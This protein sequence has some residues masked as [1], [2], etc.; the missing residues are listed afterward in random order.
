VEFSQFHGLQIAAREGVFAFEALLRSG[1]LEGVAGRRRD[2]STSARRMNCKGVR[3][4]PLVEGE[5]LSERGLCPLGVTS[6]KDGK[7][8]CVGSGV[9]GCAG[10][11]NSCNSN[12]VAELIHLSPWAA[13][14]RG[15]DSGAILKLSA[16]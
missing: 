13:P 6:E 2:K 5:D 16:K 10:V 14:Q 7:K 11:S 4:E 3:G 1:V 8:G 12:N 9:R 15:G